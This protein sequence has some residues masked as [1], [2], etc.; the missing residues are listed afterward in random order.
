V[1]EL[2]DG[3][4]LLRLTARTR[5]GSVVREFLPLSL[6]RNR[7][8]RISSAGPAA[9]EPSVSGSLVVWQSDRPE[10]SDPITGEEPD[11]GLDLFASDLRHGLEWAIVRAPGHQQRADISGRR[12][13][14]QDERGD[15][16]FGISSCV[17]SPRNGDCSEIPVASG[18]EAR[19]APD[20][21]GD[22]IVWAEA[23]DTHWSAYWCDLADGARCTPRPV[24]PTGRSQRDAVVDGR[25]VVF[26][27]QRNGRQQLLTCELDRAS[28]ECS[29]RLVA[30][31]PSFQLFPVVSGG[32]VAWGDFLSHSTRVRV[33]EIES[34]GAPCAPVAIDTRVLDP[35]PA[36]SGD[37]VVW[38]DDDGSGE[39]L[40]V[41][42][43]EYDR[44]LGTC[45]V[46]RLTGSAADQRSPV[47]D[48]NR[49]VWEDHRSG[50][51]EIFGLELPG[52]RR[53]G[54]QKA[55]QGRMLS[56][57]VRGFD[58][59]RSGLSLRAEIAGGGSLDALGAEFRD[60][61]RG[62]GLLWWMPGFDQAGS[63]AITVVAESSGLL[64]SSETFRVE[65]MPP[66]RVVVP[67]W[68]IQQY[69]RPGPP[70]RR[71]P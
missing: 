40:D 10:A 23:G 71:M 35:M 55:W 24:L 27:D 32:L 58:G 53:I 30:P 26:S 34:E 56:V 21:S 62:H 29:E 67:W 7:P 1:A 42:Y 38:Q 50:V 68:R 33:C 57:P 65:V 12:I 9:R 64:R 45:P 19:S 28:G 13:A 44:V 2:E 54:D 14:W 36:V 61:G 16:R 70:A 41:Y 8:E 59:D 52:L 48:G 3:P 37:R 63:H 60:L 47:I 51:A 18:P 69:R 49:V 15:A 43:C 46:Q 22:L 11:S 6:E 17:L 20:V 5:V 4:W 25:R 66:P 31:E 39:N